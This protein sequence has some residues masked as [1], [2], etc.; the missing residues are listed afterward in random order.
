VAPFAST[1]NINV[2]VL[3]LAA[4]SLDRFYVIFYPLQPKLRFKHFLYIMSLIWIVS[5]L[6]SSFNLF[7]YEIRQNLPENDS[8]SG[9]FNQTAAGPTNHAE[10][11]CE[12]VNF[13]IFHYFLATEIFFQFVLPLGLITFSVMAIYYKIEL[14][15]RDLMCRF[16]FNQS[17]RRV[18]NKKKVRNK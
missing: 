2:S 6:I 4:I 18:E 10:Y 11:V 7:I 17:V 1:L 16:D 5:I 15:K 12:V 14:Q 8:D 3:T 9:L 13:K